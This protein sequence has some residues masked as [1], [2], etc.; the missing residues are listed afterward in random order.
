L[1]RSRLRGGRVG[2]SDEE[3]DCFAARRV[4]VRIR[5]VM[6]QPAR[7]TLYV[8]FLRTTVPVTAASVA[9]QTESGKR[10]VFAQV[11]ASG[12]SLLH[13]SPDCFPD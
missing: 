10:L 11:L 6:T 4:L 5:A 9:V 13:T 8:G 3:W 1:G 12:D 7:L 2:V